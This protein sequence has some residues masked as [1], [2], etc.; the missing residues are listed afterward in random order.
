MI[1]K[2]LV[3]DVAITGHHSEYIKHLVDY[4]YLKGSRNT[5]Y[6]FVVHTEF[7]IHFPEIYNKGNELDFLKWQPI[8]SNELRS[9]QNGNSIMASIRSMGILD[10]YAREFEVKEVIALDFHTIKY[11][12]IFKKVNYNLSAIL[13]LQFHRLKRETLKESIEFYKRYYLTKWAIANKKLKRVF[14]LNDQET[15]TYMNSEF[16]TDVFKMLPDPIPILRPLENF[17]IY[18]HYKIDTTRKI[19]LHIGALGTRKGTPEVIESALHMDLKTQRAIAILLVGRAGDQDAEFYKKKIEEVSKNTEV[20]ILW[21]DQ[22]VS[23]PTMKSLFDQCFSVLIPYKNAEF[24]SGI[25]GHA[26]AASRPVIATNAG[27][28]KELVLTYNLGLLIEEPS[29]NHLGAKI[30][31]L[32]ATGYSS[33]SQ[34]RFVK[35]HTPEEFAQTILNR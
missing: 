1:N 11:G 28:I 19:F 35:E 30:K 16:K 25:L 24:S 7:M 22:F 20:Q 18:Q 9:A 17:N 3:Y 26:A 4:L 2:I 23:T 34:E 6:I 29:A 27:L 13:F 14:V 21:H 10:K 31:E 15:V 8:E 12:T 32:L 5:S 33:Q